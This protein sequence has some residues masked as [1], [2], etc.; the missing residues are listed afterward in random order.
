MQPLYGLTMDRG[1]HSSAWQYVALA[2]DPCG[3]PCLNRDL[4]SPFSCIA[5]RMPNCGSDL[6]LPGDFRQP[7]MAS[8]VWHTTFGP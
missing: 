3:F 4:A 5:T 1:N 2:A 7:S 6:L 8:A